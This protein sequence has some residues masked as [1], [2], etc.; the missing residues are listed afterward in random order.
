MNILYILFALSFNGRVD[1]AL[2]SW[3]EGRGE[4]A[5]LKKPDSFSIDLVPLVGHV[6]CV[7]SSCYN[8]E[9]QISEDFFIEVGCSDNQALAIVAI[10]G[11]L[12]TDRFSK[13]DITSMVPTLV[14]TLRLAWAS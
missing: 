3:I 13:K 1:E 11:G 8:V 5:L 2:L 6:A 9:T 12:I 10:D 14:D 7:V 4:R